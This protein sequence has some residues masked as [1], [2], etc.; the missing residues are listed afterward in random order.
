MYAFAKQFDVPRYTA[1]DWNSI[2]TSLK[3]Y[4]WLQTQIRLW[5]PLGVLFMIAHNEIRLLIQHKN[6]FD[7]ALGF[8]NQLHMYFVLIRVHKCSIHTQQLMPTYM[9]SLVVSCTSWIGISRA[10]RHLT[11]MNKRMLSS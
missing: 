3:N 11:A 2:Y 9:A 7:L 5:L 10:M 4:V 8:A 1:V 6:I